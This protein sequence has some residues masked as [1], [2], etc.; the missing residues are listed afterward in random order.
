M[1]H[2][3]GDDHKRHPLQIHR[4]VAKAFLPPPDPGYTEVDH[5]NRLTTDNRVVNLR[6]QTPYA[7]KHHKVPLTIELISYI[8]DLCRR[9]KTPMEIRTILMSSSSIA[10]KPEIF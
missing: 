7:N 2:I 5:I 6:W 4:L 10:G 8:C 1:I 3:R 9:K